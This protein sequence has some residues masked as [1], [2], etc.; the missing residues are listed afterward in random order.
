MLRKLSSFTYLN[1]AQF[2][3]ALNDNIYKLLIVYLFIQLEG[4]KYSHQILATTGAIFVLPFLLFSAAS[5]ALADRVSKRNIVIWVKALEVFTMS[6]GIVAFHYE[7]KIASYTILFLLATQSALFGPSKYGIIPELVPPEKISKANGIIT[8]FTY[9]AIILGTFLA[10]FLIDITGRNFIFGAF[11]CLAVAIAGLIAS[12]CIQ[13]TP[14]AGS[15]KKLDAHFFSD[16]IAT[17]KEHTNQPSLL[18]AMFGSS[19]FLFLGAFFQL[20]M[21]PYAVQSLNLTDVQ[22]GYLFLLTA[23]GIGAGAIFAGRIS[24]NVVELGLVPLAGIGVVICCYILDLL[25]EQLFAVIPLVMLLG[26]FGGMYQIPLDSYIQVASP[27]QSRGKVVAATNFMSFTGVLAASALLYVLSEWVG[28]SPDKNFTV[29]GTITLFITVIIGY[30][31]YDYL[32]RF[33]GMILSKLHFRVTYEGKEQ[34][35]ESPAIYICHHTA[36]NDTL[37]L[38]GAQRRR[39]RFFIE[40]EQTHSKWMLRI[41]RLLKVIFIPSIEPLEKSSLC[42]RVLKN[43]LNRGISVCIFTNEP[44]VEKEAALLREKLYTASDGETFP[45]IPVTIEKGEKHRKSHFF[46]RILQKF[47][48]PA[49]ITFGTKNSFA[50]Q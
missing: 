2:S 35:P 9:L 49:T 34:I 13:Y 29:I 45:I 3:G 20:N 7:S 6:L 48:V 4:I 32:T 16:I 18:V 26:M 10:S 24:G 36:W 5:G 8:S 12:L 38:L 39:M 27:Q 1:I 15:T 17:I 25:S 33:I 47:H 31:Y 28:L 19:F 11:F 43:S 41:Y 44:D 50:F 37:L 14:P 42:L 23:I 30:Q 46:W 21:I 22:G 40:Q